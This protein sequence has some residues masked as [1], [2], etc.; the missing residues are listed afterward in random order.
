MSVR[1]VFETH[2]ISEDNEKGIAT[3]WLQGRLSG[4]GRIVAAELGRRRRDTGLSAVFVSDLSRALET[5]EIAFSDTALP[6]CPDE[7]LRE[8]NYG[9]LNGCPMEMLAG[10]RSRYIDRPFPGGQSYRQVVAATA[11]FLDE[12]ATHWDHEQILMIAHSANKWA[13][14]CLLTGAKLEKLVDAPFEWREGW[15]Y[16]LNTP[17]TEE[18]R[19]GPTKLLSMDLHRRHGGAQ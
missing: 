3:G 17:L 10:Q 14:D 15:T 13:L 6:I 7:R 11:G 12:I 4:R 18:G 16:T 2:S 1:I 9:D 5:A 19:V 8:C